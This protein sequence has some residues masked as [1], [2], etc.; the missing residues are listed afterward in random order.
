MMMMVMMSCVSV[1][2][3]FCLFLRFFYDMCLLAYLL[4]G[5][6]EKP[7]NQPVLLP[8]H[9][10]L[11]QMVLSSQSVGATMY[12]ND[13]YSSAADINANGNDNIISFCLSV[14]LP[15]L[16]CTGW[17]RWLSGKALDLRSFRSWVQISPW[18][19]A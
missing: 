2:L 9:N 10:E 19:S 8:D 1:F 18:P 12:D 13:R 16:T 14:V 15:V 17:R 3:Y 6:D 7:V 5:G 4:T 11:V